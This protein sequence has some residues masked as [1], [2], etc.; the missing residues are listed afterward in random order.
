LLPGWST[1]VGSRMDC[2]QLQGTVGGTGV[3]Q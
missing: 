1:D 2:H 3:G